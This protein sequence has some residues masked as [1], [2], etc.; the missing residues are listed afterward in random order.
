MNPVYSHEMEYSAVPKAF[1]GDQARQP[2]VDYSVSHFGEEPKPAI[3]KKPSR[4]ECFVHFIGILM[5][6]I[7]ILLHAKEVYWVDLGDDGKLSINASLKY[8]QLAAKLHEVV[9]MASISSVLLFF[10]HKR[11]LK[12]RIPFG[13]LDAPYIIGA[14]GGSGLLITKRFWSPWRQT[15]LVFI[16]L[17]L[18]I[19]YTLA[20]APSSAIAMIP[21]LRHW[22]I[23]DPYKTGMWIFS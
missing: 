18:C 7:V 16:G 23:K 2:F 8:L 6:S 1:Q 14:G 4:K 13:Y 21:V 11:L 22:P 20:L 19:L 10:L 5:T 17:V 12:R 3:N 9:M 15:T